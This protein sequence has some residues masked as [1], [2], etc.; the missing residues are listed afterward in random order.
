LYSAKDEQDFGES[1]DL[2]FRNLRQQDVDRQDDVLL[3]FFEADRELHT[4]F[5]LFHLQNWKAGDLV[6][7]T[8]RCFVWITDRYRDRRE[9]CGGIAHYAPLSAIQDIRCQSSSGNHVLKLSF[10]NSVT[11]KIPVYEDLI[12]AAEEFAGA[13]RAVFK[14]PV[15]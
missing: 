14:V 5:L 12:F 15:R 1:L 9:F 3:Q 6:A 10:V 8:P 7:V 2:K 11:W 4:R 13:V